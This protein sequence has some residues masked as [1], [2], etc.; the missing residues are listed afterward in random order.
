MCFD[1]YCVVCH[2]G[3]RNTLCSNMTH[4]PGKT[5]CASSL[6]FTSVYWQSHEDIVM[7]IDIHAISACKWKMQHRAPVWVCIY[8]TSISPDLCSESQGSGEKCLLLPQILEPGPNRYMV[9]PDRQPV[10]SESDALS[11]PRQLFV[12]RMMMFSSLQ[13]PLDGLTTA[14]SAG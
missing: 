6:E 4:N 11:S 9:I 7:F 12:M 14:S 2:H 8:R 13:L 5:V 10:L 1:V 3:R